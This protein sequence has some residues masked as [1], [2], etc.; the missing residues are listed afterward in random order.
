MIPALVYRQATE[1]LRRPKTVGG[2]MY[3][4]I[5][6][7]AKLQIGKRSQKTQLIGRSP[8][9]RR[10]SALGCSAIKEEEQDEEE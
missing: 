6:V 2:I 8:L 7:N 5:L 3:Q 9:R 4:Q 10:K 1:P